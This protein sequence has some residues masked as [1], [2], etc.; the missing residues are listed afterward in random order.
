MENIATNIEKLYDKA[1]LY[2]KT[3]YELVRLKA[4]DKISEI[5]SS[6]AVVISIVFIVAMFTL[7]LNVGIALWIGQTLNN[8]SLGFFIVSGFYVLLAI[9]VFIYRKKL[10]KE[11]I[12]NL[13][14]GKLLEEKIRE[15]ND[16][17]LK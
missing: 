8:I 6:L 12:D 7:F 11:P 17:N 13:I 16:K 14:V 2:A 10:I 1:T 5:I 3:S 9:I 4:I 15:R